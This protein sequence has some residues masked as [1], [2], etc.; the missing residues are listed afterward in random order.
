MPS[1]M[2][3]EKTSD[4]LTGSQ[5][6]AEKPIDVEIRLEEDRVHGAKRQLTMKYPFL[7]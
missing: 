1:S 5:A 6:E 3:L 7:K 4:K 2:L